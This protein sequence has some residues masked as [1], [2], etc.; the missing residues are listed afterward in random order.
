MVDG[1]T[2]ADGFDSTTVRACRWPSRW[3][4][5]NRRL[6]SYCAY[7]A[8]SCNGCWNSRGC[9]SDHSAGCST[10]GRF[11]FV[12]WDETNPVFCKLREICDRAQMEQLPSDP[13]PPPYV[14]TPPTKHLSVL[15]PPF[16]FFSQSI[17]AQPLILLPFWG[18]DTF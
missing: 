7:P 1:F 10:P 14:S 4:A 15:M 2:T 5:S 16:F 13:Q 3:K 11:V 9:V 8:H 12:G 17:H 18:D 6:S